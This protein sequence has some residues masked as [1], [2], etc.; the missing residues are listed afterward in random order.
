MRRLTAV[1]LTLFFL[2]S[3]SEIQTNDPAEV[4]KYWSG[5][6]HPKELE[7]LKGQYW[8]SANWTKEYIVYLKFR[9]TEKW[10]DEFTCEN[11]LK[12][13]DESWTKPINAPN[14]FKP[15]EGMII[16]GSGDKFD[17]GSRYFID[18]L[19]NESYIYE[20]QL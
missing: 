5:S 8:Q 11:K 10:W 17:Q 18:T 13:K 19:T 2:S 7:L 1:L 16:Y 14:W 20:I 15:S 6:K 3:C 9:P 12:I 4:Y